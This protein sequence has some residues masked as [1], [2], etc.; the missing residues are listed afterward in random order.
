MKRVHMEIEWQVQ[1]VAEVLRQKEDEF[2]HDLNVQHQAEL[3]AKWEREREHRD[4][5]LTIIDQL[6]MKGCCT[7]DKPHEGSHVPDTVIKEMLDVLANLK[8]QHIMMQQI[9][10][11][12]ATTQPGKVHTL[13]RA[14]AVL[15]QDARLFVHVGAKV[16][17]NYS[18]IERLAQ[19]GR[20]QAAMTTQLLRL[21][22]PSGSRP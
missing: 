8:T 9:Q 3:F 15:I 13:R 2:M 17:L 18:M 1:S 5:G 7:T 14:L 6:C 4:K 19:Q 20:A 21:T 22:V 10:Q 11:Q 16:T 12:M